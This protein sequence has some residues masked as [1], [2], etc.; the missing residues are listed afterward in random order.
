MR[1]SFDILAE[2]FAQDVDL[3]LLRKSLAK[4]PTERI[5]W[6]E[7]MQQFGEEMREAAQN[8]ASKAPRDPE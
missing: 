8:A 1:S 7:Q 3:E 6:L 5:E 4:T 2:L